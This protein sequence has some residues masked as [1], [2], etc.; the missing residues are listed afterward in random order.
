M[1]GT[2]WTDLNAPAALASLI[3]RMLVARQGSAGGAGLG[4][5]IVW[6]RSTTV[7]AADS[8]RRRVF[9]IG[10]GETPYGRRSATGEEPREP[11]RVVVLLDRPLVVALVKLT[12]SHCGCDIRAT[13]T[14]AESAKLLTEWQPHLAILDMDLEGRQVMDHIG[15]TAV[16][17]RLA[18]IGLTRRGDLK[19]KLAAFDAGVDDILTVPFVL[20]ELLTRVIRLLRR[21]CSD[22]LTFTPVIRLGELEIDIL[23]S[24]VRAGTSQQQL[25]PLEQSLLYLLAANAA[26]VVTREEI[27]DTLWGAD[28]VT[29]SSV[30]NRHVRSLR[31]KLQNDW[32]LPRFIV[33]EPGRGYRFIPSPDAAGGR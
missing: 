33:T 29:E 4:R 7:T 15:V 31:A 22:A 6:S 12:L 10:P 5:R 21:C 16:R 14:A 28:Y 3:L 11:P 25:T 30:V 17:T 9:L 1:P 23:N 18:V 20:E 8:A 24:T 26:R 32:R 13:A 2:R 19:N 27:L